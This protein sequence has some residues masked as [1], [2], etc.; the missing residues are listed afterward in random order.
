MNKP[1]IITDSLP[2]QEAD[3]PKVLAKHGLCILQP[4]PDALPETFTRCLIRP[5][6]R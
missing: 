1:L 5:I 2:G 6:Q 3:N 4:D